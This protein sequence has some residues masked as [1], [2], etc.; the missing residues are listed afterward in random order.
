MHTV[1]VGRDTPEEEHP[2]LLIDKLN[3]CCTVYDFTL[4]DP[5]KLPGKK[6]KTA[7]LKEISAYLF[8]SP[9]PSITSEE[10]VYAACTHLF[11]TNIFRPLPPPSVSSLVSAGHPYEPPDSADEEDTLEPAWPHLELVYEIFLRFLSLLDIKTLFLKKYID[12]VFILNLFT[13][14]DTE[15]RRERACAKM[16]L[17]KIYAKIIQLRN[18]I[19]SQ[20]II[21]FQ[22]FVYESEQFNGIGELLEIFGSIVSGYQ[23]P[24]KP[25][26]IE[27]LRKVILPLH[28]PWSISTY[29]PQLAYCIVQF[30]EKDTS[31]LKYIVNEGILR[32]WPKAHSAKT[33][34][35]LNELEE[36][37]EMVNEADFV[38]VMVPVFKRLAAGY[39]NTHFQLAERSLIVTYNA[40]LFNMASNY[41]DVILPIVLPALNAALHHWHIGIQG[42]AESILDK[43][44]EVNPELFDQCMRE[45]A[46]NKE[47]EKKH[48]DESKSLWNTIEKFAARHSHDYALLNDKNEKRNSVGDDQSNS[49]QKVL[50]EKIFN[51]ISSINP[52]PT[53]N[54]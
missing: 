12:Q 26:Q 54:E 8:E 24:L 30:L 47:L 36:C 17:H 44:K 41:V 15:D 31:L 3:F 32:F 37:L 13:I 43:W 6:A 11:A 28:K 22:S 46:H 42:H 10:E 50:S 9:A 23:T 48:H 4:Y 7:T 16:I 27:S 5:S 19:R 1:D 29:H 18:F 33:V 49:V 53:R 21:T 39:T 38:T 35:F 40:T 20:M 51:G 34:M 52:I 25:E 2:Q 14:F 45:L